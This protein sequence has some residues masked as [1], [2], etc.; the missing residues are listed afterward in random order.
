[1]TD[2]QANWPMNGLVGMTISAPADI[3]N[4]GNTATNSVNT[5]ATI[6]FNT[7]T[8]LILSDAGWSNG[9]PVS[10]TQYSIF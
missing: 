9:Q 5:T 1:M 4:V 8:T 2:T 3:I 7:G 10:G 6:A